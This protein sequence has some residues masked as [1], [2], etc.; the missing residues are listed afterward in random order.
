M[1]FRSYLSGTQHFYGEPVK[2]RSRDTIIDSDFSICSVW[3]FYESS[4]EK[5]TCFGV[6]EWPPGEKVLSARYVE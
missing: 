2:L 3:Q 1:L 5:Y 6:L 4:Q